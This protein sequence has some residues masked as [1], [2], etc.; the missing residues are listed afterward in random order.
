[1]AVATHFVSFFHQNPYKAHSL[2]TSGVH[3]FLIGLKITN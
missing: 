1:M 2:F 3:A